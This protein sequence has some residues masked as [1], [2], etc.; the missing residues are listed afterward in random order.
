MR[1]RWNLRRWRRVRCWIPRPTWADPR[2]VC[3]GTDSNG[4]TIHS[5]YLCTTENCVP[6]SGSSDYTCSAYTPG[7]LPNGCADRALPES[8]A[9]LASYGCTNDD[10][11]SSGS[12]S[13]SGYICVSG[14]SQAARRRRSYG[15]TALTR[16]AEMAGIP[17][18]GQ[19]VRRSRL[20]PQ[21]QARST[22]AFCPRGQSACS[23]AASLDPADGYDCLDT[24]S[25]LEMCGGCPTGTDLSDPSAPSGVDCSTLPGVNDVECDGGRCRIRAS[26]RHPMRL[27]RG[28]VSCQAGLIQSP[29]NTG[30]F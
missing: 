23:L 6:D 24:L 18:P 12:C 30:C 1:S 21:A 3:S 5:D 22:N 15:S 17:V 19:G 28:A 13:P 25:S 7:S 20:V 9:E 16:R 4:D 10:M 11:C 8:A 14:P 26:N 29:D 27:L 2:S